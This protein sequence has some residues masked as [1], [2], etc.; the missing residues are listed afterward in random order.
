MKKSMWKSYSSERLFETTTTTEQQQQQQQQQQQRRRRQQR[1][2]QQH[3]L[4]IVYQR[5]IIKR[6]LFFVLKGFHA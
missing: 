2:R 1:R 6:Q 4:F 3:T 5:W